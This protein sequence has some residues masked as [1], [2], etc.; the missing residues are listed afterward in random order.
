MENA[1]KGLDA[2]KPNLSKTIATGVWKEDSGLGLRAEA[3]SLLRNVQGVQ[4]DN[5]DFTGL[6]WGKAHQPNEWG[7]M[8]ILKSSAKCAIHC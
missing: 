4:M 6:G 2:Q 3:Q 5:K 1:G 8:H 7:P